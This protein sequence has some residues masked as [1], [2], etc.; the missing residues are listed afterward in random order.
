MTKPGLVVVSPIPPAWS[1]IADYTARLLPFLRAYWELTIVIADDDPVPEDFDGLVVRWSDWDQAKNW[2]RGERILY[3]LGNSAYHTH[4]PQMVKRHGGVVLAHDIRVTAL[5]CLR[6]VASSDPHFISSLVFDRHGKE[7]AAEVR[8]LEDRLDLRDMA[9]FARLR[10]RLDEANC[11]LLGAAVDGADCVLVHSRLAERLA[12][13]ELHDRRIPVSVAPF[14][15]PAVMPRR[16][17]DEARHIKSFGMVEPEKDP[18]L[19]IEAFGIVFERAHDARLTFVGPVGPAIADRLHELTFQLDVEEAVTWT[20]RVDPTAYNQHL[21]TA[22][23]A[24]QLRRAVNGEASAAVSDC[25]SSGLPTIVAATGA[26][27]ELPASAALQLS[28]RGTAFEL[29]GLIHELLRHRELRQEL[30]LGGQ[31]RARALSFSA[32][33]QVLTDMLRAAPPVRGIG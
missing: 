20:G 30:S 10:R 17:T 25:L 15:H 11:M 7:L 2:I 29:A 31:E 28:A 19:L 1:G 14:G 12:N 27:V 22:D 8:A 6:A 4:V 33:S 26:M 21:E 16:I 23:I 3:C 18:E 9:G 5:H 32:V 13:L 24:V